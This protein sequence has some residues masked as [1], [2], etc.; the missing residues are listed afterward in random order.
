MY[1]ENILHHFKEPHH[2][3]HLSPARG[4]DGER[5]FKVK[6]SNPLCGDKYE[7]EIL[8]DKYGLIK[9]ASFTGEGCAI[10]KAALS[11][12]TDEII[13][14]SLDEASQID[15]KKVYELLGVEISAGRTKCALLGL[16]TFKKAIKES[17][18]EN[19]L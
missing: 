11:M 18:E 10:S 12:L 3:G 17:D 15:D 16:K 5:L 9:D 4:A 6:E 8:I 2:F 13:G 19:P 7:L 14:K 1:A